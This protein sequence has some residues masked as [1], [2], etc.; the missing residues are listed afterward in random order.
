MTVV[1]PCEDCDGKGHHVMVNPE[2]REEAVLPC[3][4]CRG[5]GYITSADNVGSPDQ[6]W[7]EGI[8]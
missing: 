3:A 5:R 4:H 6:S 1:M 7:P 2:T 8:P